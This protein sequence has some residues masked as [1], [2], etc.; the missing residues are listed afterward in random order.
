MVVEFAI[1]LWKRF[2]DRRDS[3][4]S[5]RSVSVLLMIAWD[6]HESVSVLL[7][8]MIKSAP[9][10]EYGCGLHAE[11]GGA[12]GNVASQCNLFSVY[13]KKKVNDST[14]DRRACLQRARCV[15]H[16]HVHTSTL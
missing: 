7:V 13:V 2:D 5:P 14:H 9:I 12:K 16:G 3:F 15:M 6:R 4:G 8:T 11:A 10:L 1:R